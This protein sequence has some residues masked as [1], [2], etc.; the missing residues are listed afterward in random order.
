M[1]YRN[2]KILIATIAIGITF[3]SCGQ[4]TAKNEIKSSKTKTFQNQP[5]VELINPSILETKLGDIQLVDVRTP[6]EYAEGHIKG[7]DNINIYDD[8]FMEQMSKLD[9]SKPVYVYCRSGHRSGNSAKML[10][11]AGFSKVYDLKGGILAWKS[12]NKKTEK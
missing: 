4:N 5:T 6:K 9:K 11:K 8:N 7:A 12:E 3:I 2:I 10:K 1:N